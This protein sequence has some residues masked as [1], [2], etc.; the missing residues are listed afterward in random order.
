MPYTYLKRYPSA[1]YQIIC[2]WNYFVAFSFLW[3][4]GIFTFFLLQQTH[5]VLHN[6][7]YVV[8]TMYVTWTRRENAWLLKYSK[9]NMYLNTENIHAVST[10]NEENITDLFAFV[11]YD[12]PWHLN[13]WASG[14]KCVQE[15]LKCAPRVLK[16][17]IA[18]F[19]LW[20][21]KEHF[22]GYLSSWRCND[23][24]GVFVCLVFSVC[25][26]DVS[27]STRVFQLNLKELSK[28][29]SNLNITKI[30]CKY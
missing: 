10:Q 19:H 5:S 20:M 7:F 17:E 12:K 30:Y 26:C 11:M 24:K 6:T 1:F 22:V 28:W 9:H 27:N 4:W 14:H 18:K 23:G 16:E 2:T 13:V 25:W 8:I 3:C 21:R 15:K 29:C